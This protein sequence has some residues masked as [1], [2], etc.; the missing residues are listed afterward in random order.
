[1]KTRFSF[2]A[3][4]SSSS[5]LIAIKD[6]NLD[7]GNV[8]PFIKNMVNKLIKMLTNSDESIVN[9]KQVE[10]FVIRQ[11][12]YRDDN[13]ESVLEEDY[14]KDLYEKMLKAI[15]SGYTVRYFDLDNHDDQGK[16][17]TM[18][19]LP[20]EDDGSGIYLISGDN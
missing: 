11:H 6:I 2:V 3:N 12:G 15:N 8:S 9:V 19:E 5:F 20:D 13:L 14:V 4:S 16:V 10:E 17:E 7:C 18:C 1:M